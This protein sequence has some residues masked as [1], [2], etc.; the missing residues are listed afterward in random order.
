V[1]SSPDVHIV[2]DAIFQA[3]HS[4]DG[5]PRHHHPQGEDA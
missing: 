2:T 3:E 5:V 4:L 1:P